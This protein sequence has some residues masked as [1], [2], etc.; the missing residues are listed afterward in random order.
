[1]SDTQETALISFMGSPEPQDDTGLALT[2]Y[3]AHK[4]RE[5]G[6]CQSWAKLTGELEAINAEL[7]SIDR[8]LKGGRGKAESEAERRSRA[9][10]RVSALRTASQATSLHLMAVMRELEYVRGELGRH[11]GAV[12]EADSPGTLKARVVKGSIPATLGERLAAARIDPKLVVFGVTQQ[13][14]LEADE[15]ARAQEKDPHHAP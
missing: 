2:A 3:R 1:M 8:T 11:E 6:L 13:D 10:A 12:Y 7:R 15:W 9:K 14:D 4:A 5:E